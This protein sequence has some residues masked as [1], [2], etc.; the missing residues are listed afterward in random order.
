MTARRRST[1]GEFGASASPEQPE[2]QLPPRS[3]SRAKRRPGEQPAGTV[4]LVIAVALLF[5]ALLS[6]DRLADSARGLEFG[7]VRTAA[8]AVA[9]PLE[10]VGRS[11]GLDRLRSSVWATA[12]RVLDP[13]STPPPTGPAPAPQPVQPP[14]AEGE[15]PAVPPIDEPEGPKYR[16]PYPTAANKLTFLIMGDSMTESFGKYLKADLVETEVVDA[17]HDFKYSS[18]LA[19]PDFFDWPERMRETVPQVDPDAVLIMIGANDGQNMTVDG[20]PV[21]FGSKQ[22]REVYASRVAEAMDILSADGRRVYWVGLPIAR[23]ETYAEKVEVRN[24][25][26]EAEAK[27]RDAVRYVDTWSL[28]AAADGTYTAYLRDSSG[29]RKLMR[30]EDG[31]H[32]SV[33]GAHHL[34]D[35]IMG[36]IG[37]DYDLTGR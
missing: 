14:A 19:R 37:T 11:L 1:H 23:P 7:P 28:F 32:L 30:L 20:K 15:T 25:I 36:I 9:T 12:L 22:W 17:S 21:Q 6:G 5:G 33:A 13:E 26:Y 18:G 3:R 34:T 31:I 4:L 8:V 35:H 2:G 29:D 27:S 16:N 24:A 10:W